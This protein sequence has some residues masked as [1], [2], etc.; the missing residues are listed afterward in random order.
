MLG[1]WP[2]KC[3]D[4]EVGCCLPMMDPGNDGDGEGTLR[5]W[6]LRD[7]AWPKERKKGQ[8]FCVK[9]PQDLF[10]SELAQRGVGFLK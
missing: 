9:S 7:D 2:G 4:C 5:P 8:N 1:A 3:D 10:F 6:S